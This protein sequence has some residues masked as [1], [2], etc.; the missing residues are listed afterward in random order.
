MTDEVDLSELDCKIFVSG[1][2]GRDQLD[3]WINP[4]AAGGDTEIFVGE[5]E[6]AGAGHGFLFFDHVVEVY[7]ARQADL[8]RRVG[9]VSAILNEL[10]RRGLSAVAACDYEERLPRDRS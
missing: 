6:D 2:G 10:R 1:A 7:F 4:V 8:N 9:V 5:N 3:A